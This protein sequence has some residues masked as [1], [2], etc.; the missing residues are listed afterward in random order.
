MTH[1]LQYTDLGTLQN[2]E[3]P[4]QCTVADSSFRLALLGGASSF[5]VQILLSQGFLAHG[6]LIFIQVKVK[7]A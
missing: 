2:F 5:K 6:L 3:Y 4:L 7:T 1:I